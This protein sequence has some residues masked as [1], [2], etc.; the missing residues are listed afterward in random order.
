MLR[1]GLTGGIA[2]GKSTIAEHF[3]KLG[4]PVYDTDEI[5]RQLMQP[6]R[7]A[8][9][10]CVEHFGKAIV[11][12][13]NAID[14]ARLRKIV[15]EQTKEKRWLEQMLHPLIRQESELALERSGNADY[16]ILIVPLMFETGFDS[17]VDHVIVIDCPTSVQLNRLTRRDGIDRSLAERM[18]AS[19]LSNDQRLARADS[20]IKNIDDKDR[21]KDVRELHDRLL[22]IA[23][24][25]RAVK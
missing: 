22:E 8:Y 4:I 12:H 14:R 5:G 15:F 17:L 3:N 7:E 13:N 6:G 20:V 11:G 18:I 24:R 2:S 9:Q 25:H 19:Q 23:R 10:R 21:S 1:V 16:A